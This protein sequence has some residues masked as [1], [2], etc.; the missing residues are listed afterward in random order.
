MRTILNPSI[1]R[2]T[3][4]IHSEAPFT[5]FIS[6]ASQLVWFHLVEGFD[7]A[8]AIGF[9]DSASRKSILTSVSVFDSYVRILDVL[10]LM[11]SVS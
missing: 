11:C 5:I 3:F 8:T 2:T 1:L 4:I 10:L 9:E 7:I 6:S